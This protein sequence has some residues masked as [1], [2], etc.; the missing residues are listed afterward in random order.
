MSLNQ[1]M[2]KEN[3]VHLHNGILLNYQKQRH[4]EF[5]RQ[6]GGTRIGHPEWGNSHPGRYA[7]YVLTQ[8]GV[9][10]KY[11][12]NMLQSTDSKKLSNEEDQGRMLESNSK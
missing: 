1:R 11:R 7:G 8:N 5:C 12:I 2:D 6:M 10:I 4:H 3:V 9:A